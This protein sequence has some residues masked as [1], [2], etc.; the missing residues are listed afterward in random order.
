MTKFAYNNAMSASS[1]TSLFLLNCGSNLL[2]PLKVTLMPGQS[3]ALCKELKDLRSDF[4]RKLH[5]AQE[6]QTKSKDKSITPNLY[7]PGDRV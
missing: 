7:T 1:G 3:L 6:S 5:E 2:F 4:Q